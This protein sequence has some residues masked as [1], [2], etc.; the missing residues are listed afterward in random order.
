MLLPLLAVV[1]LGL[2]IAAVMLGERT[3]RGASTVVNPAVSPF[4]TSV[5]G[6]G[7][8]EASSE[9][10]AIGTP[11]SGI[12]TAIAVKWGDRV[13]SGDV[14]F[15]IDDRDVQGQLLVARA[16]VR[17]GEATLAKARNLLEVGEGL[18][19]GSSIS[20]VDL[21]NRRFDV[22]IDDAILASANAQVEQLKVEIERRIIRAPLAG[23]ILQ[24]KIHPGEYA[25]SGVVNPPLMLLGDDTR[26]HVRV[27]VNEND[28]WR[29]KPTAAAVAY[30]PG[31]PDLK[32]QLRF[33]RIE[34]YAV[35][36][37][38]LTGESTERTDTR[39]LQ[40]IYSFERGE[41]PIYIGQRMNV[42]ID[43]P[44]AAVEA[45]PGRTTAAKP[46][47]ASR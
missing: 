45:S 28:A 10:I 39:V 29:V 36:K 17:E 23:R 16:K 18:T 19:R 42:Y 4:A 32:V 13:K 37:V 3:P 7:I 5:A 46:R 11:V 44:A 12:V 8:V 30:V 27:D 38:S 47:E 9:N 24:I 20:A 31:N 33:E 22:G 26:L 40:V 6:A 35:P 1:G 21:A 34:P 41:L 25:Q 15:K 43:A 2:A 14:L